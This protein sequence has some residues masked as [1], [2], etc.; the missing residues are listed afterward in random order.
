MEGSVKVSRENCYSLAF[1]SSSESP[2]TALSV[3][4]SR[5]HASQRKIAPGERPNLICHEAHHQTG[6]KGLAPLRGQPLTCG[7]RHFLEPSCARRPSDKLQEGGLAAAQRIQVSD[8][9]GSGLVAVADCEHPKGHGYG[10]DEAEPEPHANLHGSFMFNLSCPSLLSD[11]SLVR[12]LKQPFPQ[13]P[14][15][16][17]LA[18]LY[19]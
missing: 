12:A 19:L 13:S 5:M 16:F 6:S 7:V 1:A 14:F 4:R 18:A 17:C 15:S 8:R 10:D 3:I 11:D 2:I 9:V